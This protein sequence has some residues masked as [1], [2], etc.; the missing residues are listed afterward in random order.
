[1][2]ES[3]RTR[4]YLDKTGFFAESAV[5]LLAMAMAGLVWFIVRR[6]RDRG[7]IRA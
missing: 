6:R 3:G 1:M 2:N 4:F 5:I 7:E